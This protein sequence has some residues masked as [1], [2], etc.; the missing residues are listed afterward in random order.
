[1]AVAPGTIAQQK[2][3]SELGGNQPVPGYGIMLGDAT[4]VAQVDAYW[5]PWMQLAYG[6]DD[7]YSAGAF[8]QSWRM[9]AAAMPDYNPTVFSG[10]S[11]Q[12]MLDIY[13]GKGIAPLTPYTAPLS[14]ISVEHIEEGLIPLTEEERADVDA[15]IAA[16][17]FDA[18]GNV[19]L[20]YQLEVGRQSDAEKALQAVPSTPEPL[21]EVTDGIDVAGQLGAGQAEF[22]SSDTGTTAG[23][24]T[25][26]PPAVSQ[27]PGVAPAADVAPGM[28]LSGRTLLVIGLVLAGAWYFSRRR[29]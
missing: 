17:E 2:Y 16:G 23:G 13:S 25:M 12:A 29:S 22:E 21:G 3:Q 28:K 1:M 15:K 14:V 9:Q 24:A 7:I 5:A 20:G 6:S 8:Q 19:V 18:F 4:L 26:R 10:F 11:S 27:L